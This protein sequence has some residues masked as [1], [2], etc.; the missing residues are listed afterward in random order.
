M[1]SSQLEFIVIISGFDTL[2]KQH[3]YY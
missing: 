2:I 1:L 3:G